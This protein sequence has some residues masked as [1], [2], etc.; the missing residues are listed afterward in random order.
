LLIAFID[1]TT[2]LNRL[3]GVD[4]WMAPCHANT[5]VPSLQIFLFGYRFFSLATE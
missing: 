5:N 2:L 3:L 4:L 1:L